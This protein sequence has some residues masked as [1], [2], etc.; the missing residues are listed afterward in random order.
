MLSHSL[1][2]KA[3]V[4]AFVA[5]SRSSNPQTV[6]VFS[7]ACI[8]S[9]LRMSSSSAASGPPTKYVLTYQYVPDVLEKR[10]P[11]RAD[12]LGLAQD[13]A[14]EGRCAMGGPVTPQ[15]EKVPTGAVFIFEDLEAAESFVE[16]DPYVANGIVTSHKIEEWTVAIQK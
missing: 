6:G 3:S 9:P 11:Y 12:H 13:L 16:K 4:W 1:L 5:S 2:H 7:R 8:K 14:K 15:G 10:G